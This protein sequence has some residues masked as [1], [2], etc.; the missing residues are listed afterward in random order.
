MFELSFKKPILAA[1]WGKDFRGSR[2]EVRELEE[3]PLWPRGCGKQWSDLGYNLKT[4]LDNVPEEGKRRL[5]DVFWDL[6][7]RPVSMHGDVS[8]PS[9][10]A[11]I[12]R[13]AFE[14]MSGRQVL[15]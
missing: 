7:L 8:V 3:R 12:H 11:F 15:I 14:E 1:M 10:C 4:G 6:G 9:C 2:G 13:V 5:K